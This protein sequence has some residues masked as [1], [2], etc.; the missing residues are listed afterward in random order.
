MISA[1]V[2]SCAQRYTA[3]TSASYTQRDG[4][5]HQYRALHSRVVI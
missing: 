4:L 5:L 3:Y 2:L 1:V